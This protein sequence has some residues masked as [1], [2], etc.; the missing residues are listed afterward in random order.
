M[1]YSE[2]E[3]VYTREQAMAEE[4]I[5]TT[6]VENSGDNENNGILLKERYEIDYGKPLPEHDTNGAKAYAV[7]DKISPSRRLF[8]LICSND[9]SARISLLPHLKSMEHPSVLKLIEY[10]IVNYTPQRSRNMAL[11]Y[12]MPNG[13]K[14]S[15]F[16]STDFSWKKEPEKFK[17]ALLSLLAG[18]EA[19]KGYGITHRSVRINNIYFKDDNK[20]ELVL[21]DCMAAFPAFYQPPAYETIESLMAQK[22]GRGEGNDKNDIYAAGVVLLSLIFQKEILPEISAPEILRTKLKK[23]SFLALSSEDK[24]P[25][26]Y[27][28]LFR[29]MLADLPE[30]RWDY[31]QCYNFME[32]KNNTFIT[33]GGIENSKRALSINGD[34]HY[35]NADAAMALQNSPTEAKELIASG[36]LQDWIKSGLEDEKLYNQV[37]KII[38]QDKDKIPFSIMLSKICILINPAAPIRLGDISVFPD[39]TPKAIF[40]GLKN[41][42][43]MK[44]YND[45]FSY[46]LI[47]FWYLE[48]N[49]SRSPANAGE[50]KVYINR[51][52]YGYGIERIMY[53]FD[54]DLPCT[55]PLL[56]NELAISLTQIVKALDNTYAVSKPSGLPIDKTIIAYLRCKMGK[57]IDGIIIDLNSKLEHIQISA[58]LRL[59]TSIQSKYGPAQ[60]SHLCQWM[61]NICKPLIKQYRNLKYQKFLE[62][63]V[64]KVAKGGKL[65]EI[66]RILED[67][68]AKDNDKKQF[69][70]AVSEI[71]ML[72]SAKSRILTRGTR[73]DEEAKE[74]ALKFAV[75]LSIFAMIASFV[76]N[77]I[78][79]ILN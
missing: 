58:V 21:G 28:A 3:F 67:S 42:Q 8:A 37:E 64:I 18:I 44:V 46:D 30:N 4:E 22:E 49:N 2:N 29:G 23:G 75:I 59:Y 41:R 32:G 15:V 12:Q 60:L 19:L 62:R 6:G 54:N 71:N 69:N 40:Y 52:D 68:E 78:F 73:Q 65:M 66:H 24:L 61:I 17:R 55:S 10:G 72:L 34:K 74:L 39:G 20:T 47:K 79:W 11:I 76:I 1:F 35:T 48:Q 33:H 70:R 57:K 27:I 13:P 53:D 31:L 25:S 43:D 7:T 9:T 50:F 56:G 14:A 51:Q 26:S 63:E 77:L 5:K 16:D 45:L 38:A 36:K